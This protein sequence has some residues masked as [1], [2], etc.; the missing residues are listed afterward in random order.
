M[1]FGFF[2]CKHFRDK[3]TCNRSGNRNALVTTD[4]HGIDSDNFAFGIDQWPT[5]VARRE[6]RIR[7]HDGQCVAASILR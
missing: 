1:F 2:V 3:I 4:D 5:R 7:T 6:R